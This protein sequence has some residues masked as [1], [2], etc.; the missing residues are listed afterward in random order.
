MILANPAQAH[1]PLTAVIR[2]VG[3]FL[4]K[5]W[6][7]LFLQL[8]IF[9]AFD[10]LYE[11][12]RMLAVGDRQVALAHARDI[13]S[14]ER[15]L[16]MFH[17]LDV[18]QF[19]A[20]AP[21]FVQSV[22]NWTYFNCQFS[23]SFGFLF[24]V[25]LRRNHAFAL[26][27]N[28]FIAANA[29][30]LA[31]YTMYPAAPP[32]MLGDLGFVDTLNQ[33]SVN[34]HSGLI[35]SLANPYAAMPSLH[36]AYALI[37]GGSAVL[38][39]R[40]RPLRVLWALYPAL[41]VFSIVATA[42]HFFLDAAGGAGVA[43]IAALAVTAAHRRSRKLAAAL[44]AAPVASF[45]VYRFAGQAAGVVDALA[46]VAAGTLALAL[47]ANL[48]SV[49]L[50]AAVWRRAVNAVP[51]APRMST[52]E[53]LP[54]VFIGFLFNTVLV[55]RLGEVARVAVLRRRLRMRGAEVGTAAI[56]GTLVAEQ[57]VLGA[58]LVLIGAGLTLTIV[59][60]PAWALFSLTVLG[61]LSGGAVAAGIL[62]RRANLSLPP[63]FARLAGPAR[64][65]V[66]NGL[67]L[68]HDPR[69]LAFALVL[70][71]GSWAAQ[72]AGIYWTLAAFGLPH[73][74]ASA[75][76]VFLVSTLVGLF[77]LMPGN[78][79]VFQ[80]AVAGVLA[81]SFGVAATSGAAFA[82]VLQATEVALGAGLGAVYLLAEGLSFADL[83]RQTSAPVTEMRPREADECHLAYAA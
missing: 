43:I 68:L 31:V 33:T 66:A 73:T 22:A 10:L 32:R 67:R 63:R 53:L 19:A 77:P 52:R 11:I 38:L 37:V 49:W 72:I 20:T 1:R 3:S 21:G 13:V 47:L 48:V 24:W 54:S 45:L 71:A 57:I 64:D 44:V 28:I 6:G 29:I 50:K 65:L 35:A 46:A 12:T 14:A 16:G 79:G 82:I 2:R 56:A 39:V 51:G 81:S 59:D 40:S 61:A 62:A 27:R 60:M 17:E 70:G 58:A 42:N 41:V 30:G 75:S 18:Q 26:V 9:A 36:T 74:L 78:V 8:T 7:D 23:I 80:L 76:A 5:G 25:Y 69:Q 55:A 34:H 83:R 4:P 15:S